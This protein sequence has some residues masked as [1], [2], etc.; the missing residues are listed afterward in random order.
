MEWW[1]IILGLSCAIYFIWNILTNNK[2]DRAFTAF[3]LMVSAIM[4]V[5]LLASYKNRGNNIAVD[6]LF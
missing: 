5:E 1:I 6:P 3:L 4:F 2:T